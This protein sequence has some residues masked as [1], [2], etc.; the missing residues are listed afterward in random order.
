MT[1][2]AHALLVLDPDLFRHLLVRLDGVDA[3]ER[4]ERAGALLGRR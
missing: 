3:D 2:G 1:A 4:H